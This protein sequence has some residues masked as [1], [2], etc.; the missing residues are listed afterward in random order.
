MEFIRGIYRI[1][2]FQLPDRFL[3]AIFNT[4]FTSSAHRLYIN[5]KKAHGHQSW[6]RWKTQII[7]KWAND[8]WRF[9][10]ETALESSKCNAY[11]DR[12]LPWFFQ[13]KDRLT[14]LYP[15]MSEFMIH[16]TV[17]RKCGGDLQHAVKCT[18]TEQSSAE[19]IINIL[20]AVTTRIRIGSSTVNLRTRFNTPWKY[21]VD[22]N[23]KEN[24]DNK[25]YKSAE[26]IRKLYIFQSTTHLANACPREGVSLQAC[27]TLPAIQTPIP[28]FKFFSHVLS[29]FCINFK[30]L[31][32]YYYN[33]N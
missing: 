1:K 9:T 23:T 10:V 17:P 13:H 26:A 33:M 11:K 24:S 18:T 21:S 19:D 27:K 8:S 31:N 30:Y 15:E 2:D 6:I 14:E 32:S 25:K 20:E 28:F 4:F 12:A 7:E 3:T 29:F 22:R 16:R 5:L